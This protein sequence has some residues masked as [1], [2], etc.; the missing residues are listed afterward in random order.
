MPVFYVPIGE[1]YVGYMGM[2]LAISARIADFQAL[3]ER[4]STLLKVAEACPNPDAQMVVAPDGKGGLLLG[5]NHP[6]APAATLPKELID[7]VRIEKGD[8]QFLSL[9]IPAPLG[10][11]SGFMLTLL[12]VL[13]YGIQ[14]FEVQLNNIRKFGGLFYPCERPGHDDVLTYY[15]QREWR[16]LGGLM[17]ENVV[18]TTKLSDVD[19]ARLLGIDLQFFGRAVE[20]RSGPSRIVDECE[21]LTKVDE[22]HVLAFTRRLICPESTTK[23]ARCILDQYGFDQLPIVPLESLAGSK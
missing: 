16:I 7:K 15:Q 6:N 17:K 5:P 20:M 21:F 10:G 11:S 1:R 19:K 23:D 2:G 9:K 14:S 18:G 22:K 13:T 4:L 3:L 8:N 12:H